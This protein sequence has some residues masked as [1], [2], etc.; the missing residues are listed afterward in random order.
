VIL[1]RG[2]QPRLHA[3]LRIPLERPL[4]LPFERLSLLAGGNQSIIASS[5]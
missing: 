3:Q 4:G 5:R 2:S 1:R